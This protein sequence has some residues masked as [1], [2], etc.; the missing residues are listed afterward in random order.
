M[1]LYNALAALPHV[2]RGAIILRYYAGLNSGE[3]AAAMRLPSSTVRFHL[4]LARRRLR[5]ALSATPSRTIQPS[6]EILS[7]VH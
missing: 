6:Q 4:M 7:D 3:I 2:Q 1:D 5:K